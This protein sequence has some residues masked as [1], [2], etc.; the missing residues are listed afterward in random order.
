MSC[1]EPWIEQQE[2]FETWEHSLA[3]A[4]SVEVAVENVV[5]AAAAEV[6]EKI[7]LTACCCTVVAADAVAAA[8]AAGFDMAALADLDTVA[9]AAE[10]WD[11]CYY[12]CH[13]VENQYCHQ[14]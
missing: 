1:E 7:G 8:A 4:G 12:C 5:A 2:G 10:A 9:A 3:A 13:E 14:N 11:D 6:E